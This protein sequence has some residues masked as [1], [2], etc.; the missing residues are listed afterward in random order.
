MPAG[1]RGEDRFPRQEEG[2]RVRKGVPVSNQFS[3]RIELDI[4]DTVPDWSPYLAGEAPEDAPN[5][6][7]ILYDDTGDD[8]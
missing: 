5:F 7:V 2:R 1:I 8:A 3:G 6:L 4:R